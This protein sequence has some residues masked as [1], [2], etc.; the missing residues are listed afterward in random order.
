MVLFFGMFYYI[1]ER[2]EAPKHVQE[3]VGGLEEPGEPVVETPDELGDVEEVV[4]QE[5]IETGS[6]LI[7]LSDVHSEAV[8]LRELETGK[9]LV[10]KN[11]DQIIYPASLTKIMTVILAIEMMEDS[12]QP[13][14]M[15]P[16]YFDQLLEMDASVA[17]FQEEEIVAF[18]DLL[19]GA[20]LPSGADACLAIA[21]I[22][23]GSEA[24]YVKLMNQ[25]AA[26]LG[27]EDSHFTNVTGLHDPNNISTATD[28]ADLLTYAL[29]DPLFY[30]IFTSKEY[31]SEPTNLKPEGVQMLH[32]LSRYY[33]EYPVLQET[34]LGSKT[35]FTEEAGQCLASLAEI[36]GTYYILI[37]AGAGA[38]EAGPGEDYIPLLQ[39]LHV[40]DASTI[41]GQLKAE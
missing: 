17:G 4:E 8:L 15:Q 31:S 24:G 3:A 2:V 19:Y 9:T 30:E 35:G 23:G 41:Y 29:N 14:E 10:N 1:H 22:L 28:L 12:N 16:E 37:T 5:P 21:H 20:M 27:L 33:W 38:Q 34:M 6:A 40:L 39:P 13:I 7:D 32:T 11:Q 25:K 26:E 36:D 18:R